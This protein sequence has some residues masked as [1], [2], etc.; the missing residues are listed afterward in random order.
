MAAKYDPDY[1]RGARGPSSV[2]GRGAWLNILEIR[3]SVLTF[4]NKVR[5]IVLDSDEKEHLLRMIDTAGTYAE[6]IIARYDRN[7]PPEVQSELGDMEAT[8]RLAQQYPAHFKA[9]DVEGLKKQAVALRKKV[10]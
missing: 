4:E 5:S 10:G 3:K 1:A 9:F 2:I 8:I 6:G 7:G